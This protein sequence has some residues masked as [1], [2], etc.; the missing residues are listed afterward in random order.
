ME[1]SDNW[2]QDDWTAARTWYCCSV[3]QESSKCSITKASSRDL[4]SIPE[5]L[6]DL[7]CNETLAYQR[8]IRVSLPKSEWITNGDD[9]F[10]NRNVEFFALRF[11]C[12]H[13]VFDPSLLNLWI[14]I[15]NV[16][17][18]YRK[19]IRVGIRMLPKTPRSVRIDQRNVAR[20]R[21]SLPVGFLS[22]EVA[23]DVRYRRP[24]RRVSTDNML[25]RYEEYSALIC[26]SGSKH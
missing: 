24:Y 12:K 25:V 1:P 16:R 5:K 18:F 26:A 20:D 9:F 15:D 6:N 11:V 2:L 3:N 23:S 8:E 17:H 13:I 7:G 4:H 10:A 19:D 14:E 21:A 22:I